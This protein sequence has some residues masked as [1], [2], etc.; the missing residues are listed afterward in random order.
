MISF[1]AKFMEA[2]TAL[3]RMTGTV[4]VISNQLRSASETLNSIRSLLE[5]LSYKL[6][7]EA[8]RDVLKMQRQCEDWQ[9][10]NDRINIEAPE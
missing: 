6:S 10:N 9:R 3:R 4:A 8:R 1:E 5:D 7:A 2:Q